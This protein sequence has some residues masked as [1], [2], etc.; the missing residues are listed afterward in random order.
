M[1]RLCVACGRAWARPQ[2]DLRLFCHFERVVDLDAKVS[3]RALKLGMTE[4][5]LHRP[6]VLR[7]PIDQGGFGA[8][9]RM[10]SIGRWIKPEFGDPAFQ[11]PG[12]LPSA[13]MGRLVDSAWEQEVVRSKSSL[14]D[15]LLNCVARRRCDL[16][17]H[18]TLRLLLHDDGSRGDL[19]A[20]TD[21][22]NL[23]LHQI[24]APELAVNAKIEKRKFTNPVCHLKADPQ[25]PNVLQLEGRLLTDDLSL[26]QGSR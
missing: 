8:S 6:E 10:R 12:V 4:Q 19:I 1:Q 3:H 17:L 13:K 14:L 5:Q 18:G 23:Q 26:F 24:A 15:P 25:R 9:D 11:N 22:A 20:M 7:A 16:K 2:L 21:V